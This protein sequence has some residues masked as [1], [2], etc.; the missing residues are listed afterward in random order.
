MA[1]VVLGGAGRF[2]ALELSPPG[3]YLD[4]AAGAT[5]ITCISQTGADAAGVPFPLF[6]RGLGGG[7]VTPAY[8][9]FGAVW[10]KVF[11][12]SV[13]SFRSIAAFFNVLTILGLYLL[14]RRLMNRDVAIYTV[15]AASMS[16]W[17]FQFSRIAWDPPLAPCF[18]IWAIYFLL[19]S[20]RA[21]D[22]A[23]A[24]F[25]LSLSMYSY[26]PARVQIPVLL[27][28][29][30]WMRKV[31]G[32][33][34]LRPLLAFLGAGAMTALPLIWLTLTGE[35]Q[36]RVQ[37][38]TIFSKGYLEGPGGNS[39]GRV[40][41][42][43][44]HNMWLHFTPRYLFVSG[45]ANP[46]HSTQF[47]GELSWLDTFVLATGA[48]FV[49]A[50]GLRSRKSHGRDVEES[51]SFRQALAFALVGYV[52]GVVPAALTW[53]SLP[54][55]LRSIGSWPFL[56][57]LTGL[58]MWKIT[59]RWKGFLVAATAVT[60]AFAI[61]FSWFYFS[62]YPARSRGFFDSQIKKAA[63]HGRLT[64][65]WSHFAMAS[66]RYPALASVYYLIQ[67]GGGTCTWWR[68]RMLPGSGRYG[69]IPS[70]PALGR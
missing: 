3:F 44:V 45:D 25:L 12:F 70:P 17:S 51:M 1:L 47:V 57:L 61:A 35:F 22:S 53:E 7:F 46:R 49:I 30:L 9:Y 16:P 28:P 62:E 14:A 24:G 18:L 5:N 69:S 11:G 29:L 55:A 23:F 8:L 13:G 58:M 41:I 54:H 56:S 20:D 52:A 48:I 10:A 34:H 38:L 32:G 40:A 21:G 65:D 6:S 4:E 31:H 67:Y 15:L 42:T 27:L 26:P 33:L 43:F 19:R 63:E 64:G 2:I 66:R 68:E 37:E 39:V 59:L 50:S 60:A 36:E